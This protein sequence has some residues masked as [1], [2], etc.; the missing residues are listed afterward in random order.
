[1]Q[2]SEIAVIQ[3][4]VE[5][6]EGL[7]EAARRRAY[8]YVGDKFAL[9]PAATAA[10]ASAVQRSPSQGKVDWPDFAELFAAAEPATDK[11]R[12]L[13]ACY[14]H[15]VCQ[16]AE[17]FGSQSLNSDLKNL[18]YGVS[19]ITDALDG[20][21]EDRPQLVLQLKKSGTTKQARKTYKLSAAGAKR[22]EE[23]VATRS[24]EV[25]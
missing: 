10:I 8:V 1:M 24:R 5:A 18:G 17:S 2:D 4:L 19:N 6:F 12:A 16:G 21:I 3:R 7:D 23:M 14:W 9:Q 15:Q 25:A 20:L 13:V 22:V 11:E